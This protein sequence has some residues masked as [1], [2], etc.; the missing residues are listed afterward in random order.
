VTGDLPLKFNTPI[1]IA[2]VGLEQV[3]LEL[4]AEASPREI[5]PSSAVNP[6]L[7]TNGAPK[8][9]DAAG[10]HALET[11]TFSL[12]HAQAGQVV[13]DL[14]Q[15]LLGHPGR[16]AKAGRDTTELLVTAS[17]EEM[18]RAAA[19]VIVTDFPEPV[20]SLRSHSFTDEEPLA[21]AR[22]F[23]YACAIE[24]YAGVE[25]ALSGREF[26]QLAGMD[27]MVEPGINDAATAKLAAQLRTDWKEKDSVLKSFAAAWVRYP[28]RRLTLSSGISMG[29]GIR[30]YVNASFDGA[31]K[32][33]VDIALFEE[34]ERDAQGHRPL[35]VDSRPP[36][37]KVS[38]AAG[39][40]PS[41]AS[42]SLRQEQDVQIRLARERM[43]EAQK[44]LAVGAISPLDAAAAERDLAV[45][46]ARGDTVA[47]ARANLKYAALSLEAAQQ[48]HRNGK[49]T[50]LEL[51][52]A[53][54]TNEIA[55]IQLAE[56]LK[57]GTQVEPG[58]VAKSDG[59][60][61]TARIAAVRLDLAKQ[62]LSEV[63]KQAEVGLVPPAGR[64]VLG[65]ELAV[66]VAEAEL[67]GDALAAARARRDHA[68]RIL[69]LVEKM[70]E[71]GKATSEEVTEAT[72]AAATA[73]SA[74]AKLED[75]P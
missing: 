54:A 42:D 72:L 29:F 10:S 13:E 11:R 41:A 22:A 39:G 75:Q 60:T 57:G 69:K 16:E 3:R 12:R 28:L 51:H 33:F 25:R 43:D 70:H 23:F 30:H 74:V 31:P 67:R 47:I 45:A 17:A 58:T 64:E 37:W 40:R 65:A 7:N 62:S 1:W 9:V 46:E 27:R 50:T 5:T 49:L 53:E 26:V 4:L 19:L 6:P 44:R 2:F 52:G 24:D 63:R 20:L 32:E 36:W 55:R 66:A 71:V 34:G 18:A 48:Q 59:S 73:N 56:A 61:A 35:R 21:L 8:A 68:D 15:I 38:D 14:R